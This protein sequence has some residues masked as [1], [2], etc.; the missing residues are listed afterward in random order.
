MAHDSDA[1]QHRL[2]ILER[3]VRRSQRA[4]V[5]LG[6]AAGVMMLAAVQAQPSRQRFTEIEVERINIREPDGTLKLVI[7]NSARQTEVTT[8]GVTLPIERTR[9]AGM[10]YFNDFGDEI[11][12]LIFGGD[13]TAGGA[14]LTFDQA[15]Q[16]QVLQ[17]LNEEMIDE[18]GQLLRQTGMIF[19]DRPTDHTLLDQVR[20]QNEARAIEDPVERERALAKLREDGVYGRGRMFV[21]RTA[22][23]Q[24]RINLRDGQG[25][26]RLRFSVEEDGAATIEFLDAAGKV[27]R[28]IGP[29]AE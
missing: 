4:A 1:L 12:G 9:P 13:R 25:G 6:R 7:S 29:N 14:S 22:A 5:A 10:I 16:D 17:L 21:G 15:G 18:S 8:G 2:Q 27:V 3:R 28:T 24:A 23:G 19:S 26:V 20:M 11:G